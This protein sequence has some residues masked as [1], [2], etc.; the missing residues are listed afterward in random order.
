MDFYNAELNLGDQA[1]AADC[2]VPADVKLLEVF[3][4]TAAGGQQFLLVEDK[5]GGPLGIVSAEEVLKR[6]RSPHPMEVGRWMDMPVESTLQGRLQ[7]PEGKRSTAEAPELRNC[8]TVSQD[9]V[10]LGVMTDDDVLVSWRSIQKTLQASQGDGVT[11]LPNRARFDEHLAGECN[12]AERNGSSVAVVLIDLDYFKPINDRYGHAAGDRV[13]LTLSQ[14]IRQNLRSYDHVARFGGD[15]FAAVCTACRP[16]EISI[17]L[18]RIRDHVIGM[19]LE[20]PGPLPLPTISVGACV[21]HDLSAINEPQD[22][23]RRADEA[24]YAAK[25]AGRNCAFKIELHPR[26]DSE[27]MLVRDR[28]TNDP[29]FTPSAKTVAAGR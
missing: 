23:V 25:K 4:K 10:L 9:G 11:G 29:R 19:Q 27:P 28:Y 16:G 24:L 5:D 13:L 6:V 17:V 20:D 15:E 21:V 22:I 14:A 7:M 1:S 3:Q 8:T 2:S 26:F 12:R 18:R